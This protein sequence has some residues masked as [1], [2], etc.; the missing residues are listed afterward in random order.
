MDRFKI[1]FDS[2]KEKYVTFDMPNKKTGPNHYIKGFEVDLEPY[3]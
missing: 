2:V 1:E 3:I